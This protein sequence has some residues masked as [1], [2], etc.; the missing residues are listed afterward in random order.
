MDR[1]S[2]EVNAPR[3]RGRTEVPLWSAVI[4]QAPALVEHISPRNG[5][6][7]L[8]F[9]FTILAALA[10][11]EVEGGVLN[12]VQAEPS[13]AEV[14]IG[15]D[16]SGDVWEKRDL[17]LTGRYRNAAVWTGTEMIIW[18]GSDYYRDFPTEGW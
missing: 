13:G 4:S 11:L 15:R 7:S 2:E 16:V 9:V 14:K 18:G 1:K 6:R 3:T 17:V 10:S 8:M 5:V 12:S